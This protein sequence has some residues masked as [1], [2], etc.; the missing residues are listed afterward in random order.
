DL[1][2]AQRPEPRAATGEKAA[3][4]VRGR[5]TGELAFEEQCLHRALTPG[6]FSAAPM[7]LVTRSSA[8]SRIGAMGNSLRGAPPAL[9]KSSISQP[10]LRAIV[11]S[12]ASGLTATGNPTASS[13]GRSDAES[14]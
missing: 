9:R 6:R 2:E 14:A 8:R 7:S 5:E 1:L 10:R 4:H 11:A 12:F 13:I 3:G